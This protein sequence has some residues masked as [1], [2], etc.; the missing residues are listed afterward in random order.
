MRHDTT[1]GTPPSPGECR[2]YGVKMSSD[3]GPAPD[4]HRSEP[5]FWLLATL[6]V[7][8][9]VSVMAGA[10]GG[11]FVFDDVPLIHGNHR[12]H[13]L[14]HWA[15][16]FTSTLWNT[17]YDPSA[18]RQNGG[19]WRPI[20]LS[21][22]GVDWWIGGGSPLMFHVTNLVVHA[23]NS[24]LLLFT[25]ASW[26]R[27]RLAA[28]FGALLFAVHPV[29]TEPVAWIAGRTD[30]LCALGLLIALAGLRLRQSRRP[31][32]LA[33]LGLGLFIAFGSKEAAVA[34][35]VFAAVQ[36]WME[37][38]PPLDT[39]FFRHLLGRIWPFILLSLGYFAIHRA[40]IPAASPL[41]Q[42]N[43]RHAVPLVLDAWGRY[44]ALLAWPNDLTLGRALIRVRGIEVVAHP[45]YAALGAATLLLMLIAAW[46]QRRALPAAVVGLL[47]YG[48]LLVPVSGIVWLGYY[49]SV[50]P[51]FLYIPMLGMALVLAG[52]LERVDSRGAVRI[53]CAGLLIALG[54]R[55]FVRSTDYAS[56][57]AFW[58]RE[59]DANPRYPAAQQYLLTRELNANRP[60]SALRLA[61]HWFQ[62]SDGDSGAET[63]RAGLIRGSMAAVLALTPD[64]D[65]DTLRRV[66]AFTATLA[67][68]EPGSLELSRLG[69]NLQVPRNARLL[70]RISLD[71]RQ[72][73]IMSGEA[74]SR[75]GDDA[76]AAA[77]VRSA[78]AG[79]DDC[80]TLLSTGALI[81][82]RAGE[83]ELARELAAR[84]VRYGPP[85]GH[86]GELVRIL[87]DAA[88]WN[89]GAAK[90]GSPI[91]RV[92]FYSTLG[93]FGRAYFIARPAMQQPPADVASVRTLGELAFRAGDVNTAREL[94]S[95]ILDPQALESHLEEL[96]HSV[97]WMDRPAT[98]GEWTPS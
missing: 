90:A 14:E 75:V 23:L 18:I 50:S 28:C 11:P 85:G 27:N 79:C 69:L 55:T 16:W 87:E 6:I 73:L 5:R 61:H 47:A 8:T 22:Y 43:A 93:C 94:F 81:M 96:G 84:A 58:S 54:A 72:Y 29:Q 4:P 77:A 98:P 97:R 64:L 38:R 24:V 88:R 13:G 92:G 71:R 15:E 56:E 68:G 80:W 66:Q 82:A 44:T 67:G 95:R 45:G 57:D 53:G 10:V 3:P 74:A 76:S 63:E 49:V 39:A 65:Q 51:R 36:I 48:A 20:V 31:W 41:Y 30:S 19:F 34:F 25:L 12:V 37:R 52:L 78:L 17:N 26:I 1:S 89:A 60:R 42:L 9:S 33:W 59:I 21:S 7:I 35:P 86:G 62:L 2:P 46:R 70:S 83:V 91:L 32:G 40:F